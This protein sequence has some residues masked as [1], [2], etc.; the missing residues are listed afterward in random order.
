M[1]KYL[2]KQQELGMS[3]IEDH[4]QLVP[5]FETMKSF[6]DIKWMKSHYVRENQSTKKLIDVVMSKKEIQ[7]AIMERLNDL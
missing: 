6:A 7:E 4:H 3:P 1:Q 2:L 5:R